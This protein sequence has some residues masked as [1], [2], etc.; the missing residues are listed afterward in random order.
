MLEEISKDLQGDSC[1]ICGSELSDIK[2]D[3]T[4]YDMEDRLVRLC[5]LCD[6]CT[7]SHTVSAEVETYIKCPFCGRVIEFEFEEGSIKCHCGGEVSIEINTNI[8]ATCS[9]SRSDWMLEVINLRGA[10]DFSSILERDLLI[11]KCWNEWHYDIDSDLVPRVNISF[12]RGF[13]RAWGFLM[14]RFS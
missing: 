8:Q 11:D 13:C 14:E 12:N 4:I 7:G 6:N 3:G 2:T 9:K 5:T 1:Q 10:T